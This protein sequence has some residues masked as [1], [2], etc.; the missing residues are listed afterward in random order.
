MVIVTRWTLPLECQT[1]TT[2]DQLHQGASLF[3]ATVSSYSAI[4][5]RGNPNFSLLQQDQ[6]TK[7]S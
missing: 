7:L 6:L 3:L 1:R 5:S 2:P 4:W